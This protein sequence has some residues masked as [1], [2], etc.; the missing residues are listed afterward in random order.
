M[1]PDKEVKLEWTGQGLVFRGGPPDGPEVTL[2]GDGVDGPSPMDALLLSLAGCMAV[3]VRMILEKSRVDVQGVEVETRG[4]RAAE[5]PRRYTALQMHFRVVGAGAE[6]EPKIERAIQLSRD[7]YCSV[8][9]TLQPD[10][11]M[12]TGYERV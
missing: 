6:D 2:D 9:H 5:P 7:T 10:L 12:E 1:D 3:D 11:K 4:E 8:M